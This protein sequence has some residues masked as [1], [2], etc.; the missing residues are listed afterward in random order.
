M[1]DD[2]DFPKEHEIAH[3]RGLDLE[4]LRSRWQ[5]IFQKPAPD[6]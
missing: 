4:G 1:S 2:P 6:R 5:S 3:L